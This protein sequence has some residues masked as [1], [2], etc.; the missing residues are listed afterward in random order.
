LVKA[1]I[2]RE[3]YDAFKSLARV[4][5]HAYQQ[6]ASRLEWAA[7]ATVAGPSLRVYIL[8]PLGAIGDMDAI[9]S[10]DRVMADV[11]GREGARHLAA[12]QDSV[13]DMSTAVLNRVQSGAAPGATAEAPPAF[14][15]YAE[16]K[17]NPPK[18]AVFLAGVRR[19][20]A[21]IPHSP[22]S[23]YGTFAG[24]TRVHCF[25]SG[26][27]IGDLEVVGRL[28][29]HIASGH[30][31]EEAA[32]IMAGVNDALMETETSILRHIGHQCS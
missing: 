9:P 24:P 32:Q 6:H 14:L 29:A 31:E 10:L 7:Y 23:V 19:I 15:Y 17:L 11:N 2:R 1:T 18:A 27:R 30:G 3:R 8:I 25:A 4:V 22:F 26:E 28:Q 16:L 21:S 20:A 5:A 12:F 13:V